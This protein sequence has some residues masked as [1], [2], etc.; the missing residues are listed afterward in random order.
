MRMKRQRYIRKDGN[1]PP[2]R[3]ITFEKSLT[4]E[5]TFSRTDVRM[6]IALNDTINE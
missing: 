2:N 1:Q 3:D 6:E 4:I 5:N